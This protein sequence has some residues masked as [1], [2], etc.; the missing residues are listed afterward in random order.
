MNEVLRRVQ[1]RLSYERLMSWPFP[2]VEQTYTARDTILYALGI[3]LGAD[4]LD[5][6][7][8]RFV[9]ERGLRTLPTMPVILAS[10]GMWMRDSAAGIDWLRMLHGEQRISIVKPLPP[11]ACVIGRTRIR[12]VCDKGPGKQALIYVERQIVDKKTGEL[13]SVLEQT[14]VCLGQGGFGGPRKTLAAPHF[15]PDR[16]P[17]TSFE[18]SI[19]PQAAL[20][21][22][23]SGDMNPL[24]VD[25]EIALAAGFRAPIF[26]GL[27]TL[28]VAGHAVL[29]TCCDYDPES[30]LQMQLRFVSP[31]YPG[32]TLRTDIWR[33]GRVLSFRCSV[34]E[35]R[36]IVIDNGRVELA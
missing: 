23:L 20:L 19:L 24:H 5:R 17:D 34:V 27:G 11:A 14:I 8:L 22:R 3:G 35:R 30:I 32:E 21:Y 13:Y 7:Q 6:R 1:T 15:I 4:P 28:G 36:Q 31:V 16:D 10:P 2:P 29:R 18:Q 33:Q 12:E 26:H 9:Y 25:P